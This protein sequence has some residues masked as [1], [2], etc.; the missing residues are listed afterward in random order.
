M[1]RGAAPGERRGGRQKGTPN[2]TTKILKD[3][4]LQAAEEVGV[5]GEG[6]DG[7]VG[8]CKMVAV[9]S[10]QAFCGLLGKVLPTQVTGDPDNP[11][12]QRVENVIVDPADTGS[13]GV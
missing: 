13:Q 3:A 5:D 10:P 8:Y 6:G 9:A 7:L 1:P 2:K 11:V 4:I 12:V